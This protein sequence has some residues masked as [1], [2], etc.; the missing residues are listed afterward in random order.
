MDRVPLGRGP[1]PGPPSETG[2]HADQRPG[3]FNP[4]AAAAILE[5]SLDAII[6]MDEAGLITEFNPAAEQVF[7]FA[8]ADVIGKPLADCIIPPDLR[9]RHRRGLAHFL[10]T[11]EGPLLRTRVE[12]RA[13]RADGAE[14]LVE[15]AIAPY[16]T[17]GHWLFVSTLRDITEQRAAQRQLATQYAVANTLAQ[18]IGAVASAAPPVIR[19]VCEAIGWDGGQLWLA[20]DANDALRVVA[21]W[22]ADAS[23]ETFA[24][25]SETMRRRGEGLPG[26]VW[27]DREPRWLAV[28]QAGAML[29]PERTRAAAEC[30]IVSLVAFPI[31]K[32]DAKAIGVLEFFA[33]RP[34]AP[35]AGTRSLLTAVCQQLGQFVERKHAEEALR[36]SEARHAEEMKLEAVAV[37]AGGVAHG[38]NN[39]L[40]VIGGNAE[41][42][43]ADARNADARQLIAGIRESVSAATGLTRRI[44]AFGRRH[45][46]MLQVLELGPLLARSEPILRDVAGADVRVMVRVDPTTGNVRVDPAQMEQILVNLTLNARDAMRRGGELTIE[47]RPADPEQALAR[48]HLRLAPGAFAEIAVRDTGTGMDER[49]VA[50]A[51][52]PFFTTRPAGTGAGLGLA[53]VHGIVHATGGHVAVESAPGRGTTVRVYVPRVP[54]AV[55][56]PAAA[57]APAHIA[58]L[59]RTVLV[60]EDNARVRRVIQRALAGAGFTVLEAADGEEGL[61]IAAAHDGTIDLVISDVIMPKLG[62][63][64]MVQQLLEA[65]PDVRVLYIS[66]FSDDELVRRRV[67][68]DRA[69]FLQKPFTIEAL[70]SAAGR[71]LG[72]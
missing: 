22:H 3:E 2:A 7:G 17:N 54:A 68:N 23:V 13:C 15:L 47:A 30:G 27:A 51:F 12:I 33:R 58:G 9:E 57:T 14:L 45:P 37:L 19:L 31:L 24:A 61:A 52:E 10:A 26:H 8:R 5:T 67:T 65:R 4:A 44:L 36:R 70:L 72:E 28:A 62:G 1:E 25:V 60:A 41:L 55:A 69:A 53:V 40:M 20:D 32:G 56:R 18:E 46:L 48:D 35:D 38:F 43:E 6:G 29:T 16:R 63:G 42:L 59:G 34:Q 50:R 71:L 49:T 66:G 21:G 64:P 11:G 39:L